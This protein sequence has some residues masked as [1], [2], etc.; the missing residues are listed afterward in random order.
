[1]ER[2]VFET[3]EYEEDVA[4]GVDG[5]EVVEVGELLFMEEEVVEEL[6]A[7]GILGVGF[8]FPRPSFPQIP[9]FFRNRLECLVSFE[10]SESSCSVVSSP[11]WVED[12]DTS[13]TLEGRI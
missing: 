1:M 5:T 12:C 7:E 11:S 3:I 13:A 8:F 10:A 9:F 4:V 2:S 6:E